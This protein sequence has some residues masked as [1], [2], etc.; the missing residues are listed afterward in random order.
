MIEGWKR[1]RVV[2]PFPS[3]REGFIT[4]R[5]RDVMSGDCVRDMAG[6]IMNHSPLSAAQSV[7]DALSA[8]HDQRMTEAFGP[9][10]RERV[11]F[12]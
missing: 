7:A 9:E 2:G 1:Y 10:R 3:E 5:I 12:A 6:E 8:E 11:S 4:F